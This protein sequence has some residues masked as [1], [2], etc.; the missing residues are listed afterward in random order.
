MT[1]WCVSNSMWF[2]CGGLG[3]DPV[4]DRLCFDFLC[5][6]PSIAENMVY[7]AESSISSGTV[8]WYRRAMVCVICYCRS[9]PSICFG[10]CRICFFVCWQCAEFVF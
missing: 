3:F 2:V 6:V 9:V 1:S 8:W 5:G 10:V 4:G 7:S